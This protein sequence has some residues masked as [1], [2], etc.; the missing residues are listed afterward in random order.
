MRSLCRGQSSG[1]PAN[2]LCD[3]STRRLKDPVAAGTANLADHDMRKY[4][5]ARLGT[6]LLLSEGS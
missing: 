3:V 4:Y 6:E 5:L 1:D 2:G